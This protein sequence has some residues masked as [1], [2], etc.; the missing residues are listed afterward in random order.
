MEKRRAA[1]TGIGVVSPLGNSVPALY[2]AL[3]AG[4]SGIRA[5]TEWH[6]RFGRN[7]AGAPV[8]LDPLEVRK[9]NRKV[10][11]TMGNAALFAGLAAQE[12]VS[13][14]GLDPAIFGTGRV[15]CVIGSTIGS[16]ASMTESRLK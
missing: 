7:I 13:Q 1:V 2:D 16:A 11:R 14:S 8:V 3:K 5:M 4:R 9:I 10:R 6:G 15:G 12:A